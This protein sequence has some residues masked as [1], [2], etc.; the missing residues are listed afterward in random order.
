MMF[1]KYWCND[2][3][4]M[5]RPGECDH[6]RYKI[7]PTE[8]AKSTAVQT[9]MKDVVDPFDAGIKPLVWY[10]ARSIATPKFVKTSYSQPLPIDAAGI[11][12]SCG[13]P[14]CCSDEKTPRLYRSF[15]D[16][17]AEEIF[18]KLSLPVEIPEASW[19]SFRLIH[20][21]S[22]G[23]SG[24]VA[25]R[26]RFGETPTDSFAPSIPPL[27]VFG[28]GINHHVIYFPNKGIPPIQ[29]ISLSRSPKSNDT[30]IADWMLLDAG[31]VW[32]S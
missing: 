24:S 9:G 5:R 11:H 23:V 22:S 15:D 6:S 17:Q 4:F 8:P 27:K 16:T 3:K 10:E 13:A 25:L 30:L 31:L 21:A 28:S 19:V 7:G 29:T 32:G 20:Q 1:A 14:F 18:W 12:S 2:C 26:L